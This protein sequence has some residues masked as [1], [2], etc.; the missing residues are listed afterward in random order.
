MFSKDSISSKRVKTCQNV[1]DWTE[2][3]VRPPAETPSR[4]RVPRCAVPD[5]PNTRY[6]K[7]LTRL[8]GPK[9]AREMAHNTGFLGMARPG[10]AGLGSPFGCENVGR[11]GP[12]L[13]L[14]LP[15]RHLVNS[16]AGALAPTGAAFRGIVWKSW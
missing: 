13:R 16:V 2:P 3:F 14:S 6:G 9:K 4:R 8:T 7:P 11:P 12:S 10:S 5:D 15:G 1:S